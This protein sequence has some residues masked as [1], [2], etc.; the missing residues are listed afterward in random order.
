MSD[1]SRLFSWSGS[2]EMR[3]SN[4]KK[5]EK[6]TDINT[7]ADIIGIGGRLSAE[8]PTVAMAVSNL[9]P[10][11]KCGKGWQTVRISWPD[12]PITVTCQE[13]GDVL[14]SH[15]TRIEFPLPICPH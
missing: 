13:C 10:C 15:P 12:G 8:N 1:D 7:P 5:I 2:I 3:R 14:R 4:P 11:P 9:P 6:T